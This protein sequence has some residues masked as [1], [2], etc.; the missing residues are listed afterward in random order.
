MN[1]IVYSFC[2]LNS[3]HG[4]RKRHSNK[5]E[6]LNLKKIKKMKRFNVILKGASLT[7]NEMEKINGGEM[8]NYNNQPGCNCSGGATND[9][10]AL[11]DDNE[12]NA[13]NCRCKGYGDNNNDSTGCTCGDVVVSHIIP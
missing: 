3:G 5:R 8:S 10:L 1:A 13:Q 11:C 7:S 9:F 12:N 2:F 4:K 6:R